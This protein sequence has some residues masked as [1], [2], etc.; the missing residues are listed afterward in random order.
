MNIPFNKPSIVGREIEYIKDAINLGKISGDGKYTKLCSER[1]T[2][3]IKTKKTLITTSGTHALEMAAILCDIKKGDEVILPSFTFVSTAN[4]FCLRGAKPIFV[5]I[6]EDTKNIDESLI[7][8]KITKKTKCIIPVHYSGVS[9]E[10][11]KIMDLSH[12]YNL[13]VIEDAAQGLM[14]TYK[15]RMLGSIGDFGAFSFHET[16][17]V[18]CGEGGA[19]TINNEKF[20]ERAEIIREK[21]TNRSKFFRGEVDKYTWVDIGSSYLPSDI[22]SA[23]LYAQLEQIEPITKRRQEICNLY[24]TGLQQLEDSGKLKIP[25]N[26]IDTTTNGHIFYIELKNLAERD[27]LLKYLREN[28]IYAVFHYVPLHSS[29]MGLKYGYSVEDLPVTNKISERLL[30]LPLY[31]SIRTQEID[32]IIDKIKN[33]KWQK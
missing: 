9:S 15:G 13:F 19:L 23:F 22:L 8:K 1:L 14:S 3:L 20:I 24:R 7:E 5:D 16:K 26:I 29:P 32:Y 6:R 33:Y 28:G 30:R 11:D 27:S 31:Y 12:K 18:Y 2:S 17:N 4:A 21:G 10:M 25:D